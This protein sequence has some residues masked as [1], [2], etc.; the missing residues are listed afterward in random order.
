ME[1]GSRRNHSAVI[2]TVFET[3]LKGRSAFSRR[4]RQMT[5][6]MTKSPP[7]AGEANSQLRGRISSLGSDG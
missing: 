4:R 1:F 2:F 5:G 3:S 7:M 6:L